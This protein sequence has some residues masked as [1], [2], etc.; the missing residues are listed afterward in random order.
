MPRVDS[1]LY[2][3]RAPFAMD[4]LKEGW[5]HDPIADDPAQVAEHFTPASIAAWKLSAMHGPEATQTFAT[6]MASGS[7]YIDALAVAQLTDAAVREWR[8]P[9][10]VTD[11][12]VEVD[13]R[14]DT[15]D[16]TLSRHGP[17]SAP[18]SCECKPIILARVAFGAKNMLGEKARPPRALPGP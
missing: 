3:G 4:S 13:R 15:W 1:F 10:P 18:K 17:D 16:I 8:N 11:I 12:S 14:G 5:S 2:D 7:T 6:A 9:P